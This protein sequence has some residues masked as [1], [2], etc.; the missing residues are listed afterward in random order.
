MFRAVLGQFLCYLLAR[1]EGHR[2]FHNK[3]FPQKRDHFHLLAEMQAP[4]WL[5]ITCSDSRVLP[6]LILKT[7]RAISCDRPR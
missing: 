6:D 1:C 2:R 3:I 5:F 4:E 7:E